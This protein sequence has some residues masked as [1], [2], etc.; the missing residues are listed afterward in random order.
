M[1]A[2]PHLAH[3]AAAV[4]LERLTDV[5]HRLE[6]VQGENPAAHRLLREA[7]AELAQARLALTHQH[8]AATRA[9]LD[10][11]LLVARTAAHQLN[12][13]LSPIVG[14]AELLTIL[15]G[16]RDNPT[17]R[18][19]AGLIG[20]SAGSAAEIVKRLQRIVR[21]EETPSPLGPDQ[22]LLDLDRSAAS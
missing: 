1:A 17:A 4:R 16:V 6:A 22:P 18:S 21:L 10:G 8:E 19:Y 9:R 20:E 13:A 5:L 2:P 15:P 7:A 3:S 11:A 14:Y 12:N